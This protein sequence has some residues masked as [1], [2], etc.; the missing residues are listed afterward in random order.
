[1]F[2]AIYV[3]TDSQEYAE[4]A[5]KY[6]AD[7]PFLRPNELAT[8]TASSWDVVVDALRRYS[9][10][11]KHFTTVT[12]LQPT[13][14]LRSADDIIRGYRLLDDKNANSVVAVCE[15]DHSPLW[16][17]VLPEN[18]SMSNFIN[19]AI[20]DLPRQQLQQFYRINGALYIVKTSTLN[21]NTDIYE[22]NCYAYI[23]P[24]SRSI[25]ID[26]LLDFIFAETILT[27]PELLHNS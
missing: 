14:P 7:V 1:M 4:I 8:D 9:E 22:N 23:M 5:M 25:D 13:S 10:L 24:K 21:G 15:T 27:N 16:C 3:S 26:S 19:K 20:S 12:L 17:N 2:S 18:M 6:G 11:G